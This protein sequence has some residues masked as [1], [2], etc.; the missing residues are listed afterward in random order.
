MEWTAVFLKSPRVA[1]RIVGLAVFPARVINPN[2]LK[3]QGATGLVMARTVP[4]LVLTVKT[5]RPV[6]F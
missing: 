3:G 6:L 5:S 2:E 4:F 1:F